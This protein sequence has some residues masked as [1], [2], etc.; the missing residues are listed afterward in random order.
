MNDN[1]IALFAELIEKTQVKCDDL[2]NCIVELNRHLSE[3]S[4]RQ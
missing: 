3:L 4:N 1:E 2:T